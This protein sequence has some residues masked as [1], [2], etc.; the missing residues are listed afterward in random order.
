MEVTTIESSAFQELTSMFK[1][2]CN[3]VNSLASEVK[4]LKSKRLFTAKEVAEMTGY[5]EK[6]IR[7]KRYEIGFR[8]EG[9]VVLFKPEDV[10]AWIE[11]GYVKPKTIKN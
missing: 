3:M 6:T 9:G 10:D 7:N 1:T 4:V 2:S 11:K 5:N 8:S